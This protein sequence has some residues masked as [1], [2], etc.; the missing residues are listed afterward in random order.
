MKATPGAKYPDSG[1]KPQLCMGWLEKSQRQVAEGFAAAGRLRSP[2][3]GGRQ[4]QSLWLWCGRGQASKVLLQ[5]SGA[6]SWG[7]GASSGEQAQRYLGARMV[8]TCKTKDVG[9]DSGLCEGSGPEQGMGQSQPQTSQQALGPG[10]R[11]DEQRDAGV[12][13]VRRAAWRRQQRGG[14]GDFRHKVHSLVLSALAMKTC[15]ARGHSAQRCQDG[16]GPCPVNP[17]Q[18]CLSCSPYAGPWGHG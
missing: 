14:K 13:A 18:G 9:S 16:T 4:G 17:S 3:W 7:L 1:L 10:W 11:E 6:E 12:V 5:G 15:Q 8:R 2:L